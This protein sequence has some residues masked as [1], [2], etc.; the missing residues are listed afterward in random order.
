MTPS[1]WAVLLWNDPVNLM[2]YVVRTLVRVLSIS[3]EEAKRLMLLAH[4]HGKTAVFSG[5][6]EE[7]EVIAVQLMSASLWAT[8]RHG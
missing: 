3:E 1:A 4:T 7:C 8:V 2:S 6:R 5:D